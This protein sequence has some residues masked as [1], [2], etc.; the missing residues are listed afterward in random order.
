[1]SLNERTPD[2]AAAAAAEVTGH[3]FTSAEITRI[4]STTVLSPSIT[5]AL[6]LK[7]M[8]L[9]RNNKQMC[10]VAQR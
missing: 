2:P 6:V 3:K 5:D 4:C 7:K 9:L 1:M 8:K 10:V